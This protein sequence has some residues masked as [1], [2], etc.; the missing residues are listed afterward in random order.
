MDKNT[1]TGFILIALVLIGFSW[2]TKPTEEQI[3]AQRAQ[4]SIAAV[5][6]EEAKK[7]AQAGTTRPKNKGKKKK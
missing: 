5:K 2:Y 6:I 1:I 3:A 4:D 7:K